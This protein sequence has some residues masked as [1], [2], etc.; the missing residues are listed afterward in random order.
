MASANQKRIIS[1]IR[2]KG[3]HFCITELGIRRVAVVLVVT[4]LDQTKLVDYLVDYAEA[5]ANLQDK[6]KRQYQLLSQG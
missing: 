2:G 6:T 1:G 3:L 5:L 4:L